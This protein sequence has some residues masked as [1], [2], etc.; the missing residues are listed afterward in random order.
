MITDALRV[1]SELYVENFVITPPALIQCP[2]H[3][4][5]LEDQIFNSLKSSYPEFE[6]WFI[7][8]SREG[9]KA[10]VHFREDGSIGALL[11]YKIE[12]ESIPGT[13]PL[14]YKRRLKISSF[15]VTHVG[16][17][18]GELFIKVA[19]EIAKINQ[20]NEIYFTYFPKT[21]DRLIDLVS[22]YGFFKVSQNSRGEDIYLKETIIDQ[23]KRFSLNP[24]EIASVYF[25]SFYDGP[26]VDKFV[27]PIQ[28]RFHSKLFTDYS[29]RQLHED[30]IKGFLT[31]GNA[32]RKAYI[33]HAKTRRIKT[34]DVLIFYLSQAKKMTTLGVVEA[35][36]YNL[37]NSVDILRK[38]GK[39]TVYSASEIERMATKLTTVIMFT[40]HFH[41]EHP[42]TYER[43]KIEGV[44]KGAP[45]SIIRIDD[46][47]YSRI[48]S[49]DGIDERYIVH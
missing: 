28:P 20:L 24:A 8:I 1:V 36:D 29:E 35:V 26:V 33:C 37:N 44:L 30:E 46:E 42:I 47:K 45:Q 7:K 10:W 32:I 34:G 4:L 3:H 11:I 41:F 12:E 43:L 27:V 2:V 22:E 13:R 49:L 40:S 5:N 16:F 6:S 48:L 25:P 15:K 9:R 38:V 39:R 18:I 21:D 19:C 31:E 14:P 17:K 23:Q